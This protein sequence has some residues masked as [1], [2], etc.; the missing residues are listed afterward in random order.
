MK[1][2]VTKVFKYNKKMQHLPLKTLKYT[3]TGIFSLLE[4]PTVSLC[5][6]VCVCVCVCVCMSK[7]DI[8]LSLLDL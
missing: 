2:P 5:V 8:K 7:R 6:Y 4:Y 3:I 1:Q